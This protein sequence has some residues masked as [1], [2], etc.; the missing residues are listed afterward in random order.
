[1]RETVAALVDRIPFFVYRSVIPNMLLYKSKKI[2][3]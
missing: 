1:M 2:D 3:A